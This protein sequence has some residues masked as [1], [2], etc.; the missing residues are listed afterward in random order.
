M[1]NEDGWGIGVVSPSTTTFLGG[2][3]GVKG[4]GGSA[5][6]STGYLAPT[7]QVSIPARGQFKFTFYL[8]LGDVRTIRSFALQVQGRESKAR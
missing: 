5:D 7:E 2:F 4:P 6:A 3:S 8:V 1:V